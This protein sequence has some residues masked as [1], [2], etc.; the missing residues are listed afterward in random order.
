MIDHETA[1][2]GFQALACFNQL[3][4]LAMDG[5]LLFLFFG[6]HAHQCQRISITLSKAVQLRAQRLGIQPIG[7][8]SFVALIE[9]L[10]TDHVRADPQRAELPLQAKPKPAR[11]INGGDFS[12]LPLEL[13]CPVHKGFLSEALRWFGISP[14]LLFDHHVIILVHVNPELDRTSAP[15]KLRAGSLK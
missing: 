7:L 1:P 4:P 11:F 9:F 14:S 15:I 10:W 8:Y 6:G 5:A 12:S 3:L 2:L 13:G